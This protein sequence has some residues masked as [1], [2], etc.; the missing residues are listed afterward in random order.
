[1]DPALQRTIIGMI[2]MACA[3]GYVKYEQGQVTEA[4]EVE[5]ETGLELELDRLCR[6]GR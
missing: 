4:R 6:K 3:S 5:A 2:E 1:M